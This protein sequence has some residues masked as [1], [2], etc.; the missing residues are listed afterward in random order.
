M[1]IEVNV[2]RFLKPGDLGAH[3]GAGHLRQHVRVAFAGDQRRH[4]RPSGDPENVGGHHRQLDAGVLEELFHPVLFR[5]TG[6]HQIDAVAGQVTQPPDRPRR[7]ETGAQH[8]SLGELAQ[9]DRV[10]KSLF[11]RPG[12]CLT[13]RA[14]TSHGS[15]PWASNR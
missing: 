5:R 14:L 11:G 15:S 3:P 6:S 2:E 13:S 12:R 1:I 8:L 4:H 7:Y 10:N 9:P